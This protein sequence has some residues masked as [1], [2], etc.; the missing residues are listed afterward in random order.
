MTREIETLE[1]AASKLTNDASK[2]GAT[3]RLD[4]KRP[5]SGSMFDDVAFGEH[6]EN[7]L[8]EINN[9]TQKKTVKRNVNKKVKSQ[10]KFDVTNTTPIAQKKSFDGKNN[11]DAVGPVLSTRQTFLGKRFG[12]DKIND[13]KV[14]APVTDDWFDDEAFSLR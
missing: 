14:I 7:Y 6:S 13:G 11:L 3:L 4:E 8:V 9:F 10:T 1:A 12:G 5:T 2:P